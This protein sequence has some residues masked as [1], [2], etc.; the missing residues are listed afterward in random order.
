MKY[1]GQ[2]PI[3]TLF[4][5][6]LMPSVQAQ[7]V[8]QLDRAFGHGGSFSL[9]TELEQGDA[10][11][12]HMLLQADGTVL[13]TGYLDDKGTDGF[14]IYRLRPDGQLDEN[15]GEAGQVHL[16]FEG[17]AN[18]MALQ[19]DGNILLGGYRQRGIHRDMA[20]M[21]LR[22]DGQLDET[23]G[24]DGQA[25]VTFPGTARLAALEVM[26]NGDI[27]LAG[28][29]HEDGWIQR[30]FA[31]ACLK[32][33]GQLDPHFGDKGKLL[34]DAGKYGRCEAMA[35]QPDGRILLAGYAKVAQFR[36]FVLLRLHRD[37]RADHTFGAAGIQRFHLGA[38]NDYATAVEV[39]PSRKIL[40]AGHTK[41]DGS[42]EYDFTLMRLHPDGSLD[43]SFGKDGLRIVDAGGAD[44]VSD[45]CL[46][47]DGN[48]LLG[49][50]SNYKLTVCRFN[51]R[52]ILDRSFGEGGIQRHKKIGGD[53]RDHGGTLAVQKDGRILLSGLCKGNMMLARMEGNP[54]LSGLDDMLAMDY[55]QEEPAAPHYAQL[56]VVPGFNIKAWLSTDEV[57]QAMSRGG[58]GKQSLEGNIVSSVMKYITNHG[59]FKIGQR[60]KV[61]IVRDTNDDLHFYVNKRYAKTTN[62]QE[63]E[64]VAKR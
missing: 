35:L 47:S 22:P 8:G 32:A 14:S 12:Q 50:T 24:I 20:V 17:Q 28:D 29:M 2:P 53:S 16:P 9:P 23:F 62:S 3:I 13:M 56:R 57:P 7:L 63:V 52:G 30:Q 43:D 60:C 36:D 26:E 21:R 27:L 11:Q 49:G 64:N 6:L 45:I 55:E 51:H 59:H 18:A 38:E 46:Q 37:G 34:I 54:Y 4:L 61:V 1:L 41:L 39:L 33:D 58:S 42:R 44:Y 19:A 25:I 10:S 40:L 15:F 31:V 48:I 5:V